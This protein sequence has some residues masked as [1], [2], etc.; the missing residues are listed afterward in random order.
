M[1]AYEKAKSVV[2]ENFDIL[3]A[4]AKALLEKETMDAVEIEAL[5]KGL[6]SKK[7]LQA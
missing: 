5:I 1:E 7:A 4:F 3:D 6:E 2:S